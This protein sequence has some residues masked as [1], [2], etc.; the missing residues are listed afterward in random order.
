MPRPRRPAWRG[1]NGRG[2]R[3][4]PRASA[5]PM[6]GLTSRIAQRRQRRRRRAGARPRRTPGRCGRPG[7]SARRR[8]A[9]R[10]E[11]EQLLLRHAPRATDRPS[12]RSAA[13]ASADP[14]PRPAATGMCLARRI[15]ARGA[16]PARSASRRARLQH[17][18]VGFARQR[19]RP[20][21]RRASSDRRSDGRASSV[22]A[23][24]TKATS[25]SSRW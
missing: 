18:I 15:D 19:R 8:R 5:A 12:S 9:T 23:R 17:Q 2:A 4:R 13:A 14:P 22:S 10:G 11:I 1:E 25:E 3:R 20:A 7:T 21:A 24:S 6:P 16:T